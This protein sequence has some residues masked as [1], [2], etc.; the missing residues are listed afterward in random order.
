MPE[1]G[2]YFLEYNNF[3]PAD[4]LK[5]PPHIAPI[6]Y[7]TP[8]YS[9][10]RATTADFMFV[11][12]AAALVYG[13]PYRAVAPSFAAKTK[14]DRGRALLVILGCFTRSTRNSGAWC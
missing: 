6:W 3:I 13:V 7:F 10:L 1:F 5:T 14:T 4:P 8:F 9:V 2:G 12:A 11:L